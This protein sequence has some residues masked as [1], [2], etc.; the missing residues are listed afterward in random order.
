MSRKAEPIVLDFMVLDCIIPRVKENEP[1]IY[2]LGRR[3][4][5][6]IPLRG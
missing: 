3:L 2:H 1:Q 4:V 5:E 6:D